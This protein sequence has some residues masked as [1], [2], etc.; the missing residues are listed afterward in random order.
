VE[1]AQRL[2]GEILSADS[3]QV[4]RGLDIGTAKPTTERAL[5][6][7]H[8]V[9]LVGP[10]EDFD[11][12]RWLAAARSAEADVRKRGRLPILCGGTGLYFR[13]WREGLDAMPSPDPEL[14]RVLEAQPL[15]ALRSELE[16]KA[17]EVWARIDRNNPRRLVRAVEILRLGGAP[18]HN[19][20]AP[21]AEQRD[22][23]GPI[24]VLRRAPEDLRRRM[25]V[26]VDAMFA[27][28][29]VEETRR[30]LELGLRENRT[31]LQAI[32]YRQVVEHL[33]GVRDLSA[34]VTEVKARTWQ[35]GRRQMTWF[36][37]RPGVV[38]VDVVGDEPPSMTAERILKHPDFGTGGN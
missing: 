32:G 7:H 38:W 28:G 37:H 33:E 8:L 27:Q 36:R 26:R 4:Y 12:A 13:A 24:F 31:A 5:V 17:P 10:G 25:E 35:Y 6:A 34:T 18:R 1:L 21:K 14:R 15:D 9:D 11:A 22:A 23:I 29:L 19:E 16:H 2:G 20:S 3:M 30:L